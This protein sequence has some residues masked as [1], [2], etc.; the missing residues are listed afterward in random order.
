MSP[1]LDQPRRR[2][3]TAKYKLDVLIEY[4][5]ATAAERGVLLRRGR[6]YSSHL[7]EWRKARAADALGGLA[8]SP[9]SGTTAAQDKENTKL[10]ARAEWAEWELAKT[11]AALEIV[12]KGTRALGD[13][14]RERGHPDAVEAVI[15]PAVLL[16]AGQTSTA[17]ACALLGKPRASHYRD[18]RPVPLVPAPRA[19]RGAPL[20]A[21]STAEYRSDHRGA[22]QPA[23]LRQERRANLGDAAR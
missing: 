19:P 21:L 10:R 20:N 4:D 12:G 2:S 7:S 9:R 22:D 6:L 18:R 1:R 13:A 16:L 23:V 17:M 3:F 15:T 5:A 14:L 8:P 11:R